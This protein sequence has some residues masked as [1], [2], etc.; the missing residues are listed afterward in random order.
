MSAKTWLLLGVLAL[1]G[2]CSPALLHFETPKLAVVSVGGAR[3]DLIQQNVVVRLRVQNPNDVELPVRGLTV[4]LELN[5]EKFAD[6]VAAREFTVPPRGE[7]EFDMEMRA[8]AV[9]L[10]LKLLRHRDAGSKVAEYRIKG[11]VDTKLG[12]LHS[13]PFEE[14]GQIPLQ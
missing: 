8:D 5:G 10:A 2:G 13:I 7:A 12:F 3:G 11:K 14:K 4:A 9:G 6:G 1:L